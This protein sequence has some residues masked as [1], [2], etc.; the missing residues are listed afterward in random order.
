M[1]RPSLFDPTRRRFFLA[2]SASGPAAQSARGIDGRGSMPV[3]D[4]VAAAHQIRLHAAGHYRQLGAVLQPDNGD[5]QRYTS[6]I[7]TFTKTLRHNNLGEV[8][9]ESY[10]SMIRAIQ[11]GRQEEFDAVLRGG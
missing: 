3:A 2:L 9:R 8:N 5:E 10:Q 11:T 4:R 1:A 7:N 6:L